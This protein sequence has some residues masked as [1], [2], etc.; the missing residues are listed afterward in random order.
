MGEGGQAAESAQRSGVNAPAVGGT[1]R[2]CAGRGGRGGRRVDKGGR[3]GRRTETGG[4]VARC[5]GPARRRQRN[6]A[7]G[8]PARVRARAPSAAPLIGATPQRRSQSRPAA[9]WVRA[10]PLMLGGGQAP[11]PPDR[12]CRAQPTRGRPG[13]VAPSRQ[14]RPSVSTPRT[15]PPPWRQGWVG[16]PR[17]SRH[18]FFPS[19]PHLR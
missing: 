9:A 2:R 16:L 14:A 12:P 5:T 10:P 18:D 3:R 19:R 7:C 15:P 13:S 6:D 4:S 8:D 11:L 1:C 17:S